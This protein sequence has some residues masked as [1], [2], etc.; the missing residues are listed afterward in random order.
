M[1]PAGRK[2]RSFTPMP[3]CSTPPA[4]NKAHGAAWS[5]AIYQLQKDIGAIYRQ[6]LAHGV[7]QLGYTIER[8]KDL[9]FEIAGVP[10]AVAEALSQRTAAIEARLAGA[11]QDPR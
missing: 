4:T 3:W 8:G 9:T 5:R 2:T 7:A 6:E 10:K 1:T 11:G